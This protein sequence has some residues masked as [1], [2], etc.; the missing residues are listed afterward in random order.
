M[1]DLRPLRPVL[2][3]AVGVLALAG[4]GTTS[5]GSVPTASGSAAQTASFDAARGPLAATDAWVKS[6]PGG[7]TA[8]FL[9]LANDGDAA[10]VLVSAT[11]PAS[12]TV[13]LH[14]MA[15]RGGQMVM[16]QK[17]TGIAVPA[18][19]RATLEPGGDHIMLMDLS[20]PVRAGDVVRLTLTF[21]SGATLQVAA[22]A[23][24]YA[25]A[26]ES[27]Q[28]SMDATSAVPDTSAGTS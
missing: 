24:D 27:Y 25:G 12:P 21:A 7:M 18:H 1:T 26:R 23:K 10:D 8:A 28:P 9:T 2:L 16:R 22:V 13:Q 15:M 5:A 20:A 3:A 14:E 17:A 11:T 6:A 19:G 4:C